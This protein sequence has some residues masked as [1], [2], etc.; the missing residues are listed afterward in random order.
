VAA[1]WAVN[2]ATLNAMPS[3]VGHSLMGYIIYRATGNSAKVRSWPQIVACLLGANAA[4]LDFVPGLVV[5]DLGRFHQ[6]PSHSI[7]FA[8]LFALVACPFFSR[9]LRAFV[10]GFSLYLSH[11]LLDY[12][13]QDPSPPLGVPFFW[14]LSDKYYMAPFAFLSSFDRPDI[15]AAAAVPAFFTFHNVLTISIELLFLLPLFLF[16]STWRKHSDFKAALVNQNG[17]IPTS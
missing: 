15:L 17:R 6:G 3:P 12:L 8:I 11:V 5:G 4:D 10:I 9:P 1:F 14:P 13:V 7:T 2:S 16:V